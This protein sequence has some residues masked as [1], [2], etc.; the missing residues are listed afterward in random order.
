[1]WICLKAGVVAMTTTNPI[2]CIKVRSIFT[3]MIKLKRWTVLDYSMKYQR[4]C[5]EEKESV[6][7]SEVLHHQWWWA[8]M[9]LS[10]WLSTK[11]WVILQES[12]RERL[13][14]KTPDLSTF[15]VG[16][17]SRCAAS[18]ALYPVNLIRTRQMKQRYHI[19]GFSK[20]YLDKWRNKRVL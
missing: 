12:I 10:S 4:I 9:V 3:G 20:E 13:I 7:S 6:H 8:F 1:M 5:I 14:N 2:W 17:I 15:I 16:G 18:S 11:I 19:Q